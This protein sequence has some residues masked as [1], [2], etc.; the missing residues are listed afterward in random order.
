MRKRG[1]HPV[2]AVLEAVEQLAHRRVIDRPAFG[3][4]EEVALAHIGDV[5]T[6]VVLGEEVVEGLVAPGADI[7]GDRLVPFFRVGESTRNGSS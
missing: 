7:L 3:V 6:V 1:P 5:G 2:A 4:G